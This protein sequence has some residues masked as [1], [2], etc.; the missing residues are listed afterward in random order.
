MV[1]PN[2][3]ISKTVTFALVVSLRVVAVCCWVVTVIVVVNGEV[4]LLETESEASFQSVN[5]V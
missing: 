2:S 4:V 3:T 1:T 5:D